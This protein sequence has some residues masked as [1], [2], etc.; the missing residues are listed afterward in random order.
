MGLLSIIASLMA[1]VGF[2]TFGFTETVCGT[3]PNRF[4]SG[5]IEN[6]SVILH[7]YDY[8]FSHFKH[9]AT[10]TVF[11]GTTNP[12]FQGNF[13]V[14]GTDIS[15]LF[16]NVNQNCKP[17]MTKGPNSSI[18]GNLD[19]YFPCHPYNQFG[20]STPDLSDYGSSEFCHTSSSSRSELASMK[21]DGQ[22]YYTWDDVRNPNRNL[23]VFESWVISSLFHMIS[24]SHFN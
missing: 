13:S 10:D 22:V 8:D 21:P 9:P 6:A 16:Q 19:W 2:I 7:G 12:L 3:P 5:T 14:A 4:H 1:I 17:F 18:S 15:F 23:A 24:V 20:N 11:N